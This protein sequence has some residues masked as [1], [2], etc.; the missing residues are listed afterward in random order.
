[1]SGV[2][3]VVSVLLNVGMLTP[4]N[5]FLGLLVGSSTSGTFSP[6]VALH[7]ALRSSVRMKTLSVSI[8]SVDVSSREDWLR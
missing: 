4:K 5:F 7:L 3:P 1:M 2:T 6:L 8:T